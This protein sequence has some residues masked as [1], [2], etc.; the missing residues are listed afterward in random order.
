MDGAEIRIDNLP[1]REEWAALRV[2]ITSL[3]GEVAGLCHEQKGQNAGIRR[4]ENFLIGEKMTL[5]YAEVLSTHRRCFFLLLLAKFP[6]GK[7]NHRV[8]AEAANQA[9]ITTAQVAAEFAWLQEQG[10]V[11]TQGKEEEVIVATL[12]R[13]GREVADGRARL[14]GIAPYESEGI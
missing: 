7:G 9:K 8:F 1:S 3:R 4:I 12:S 2:E 14:D 13:R 5:N 11:S 6:D 10:L